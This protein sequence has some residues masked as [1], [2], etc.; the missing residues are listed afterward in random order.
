MP[1]YRGNY[2]LS[3]AARSASGTCAVSFDEER[4]VLAPETGAGLAV[5][6]GDIDSFTPGDWELSVRLYSGTMLK[7][8]RFG[9]AFPNLQRELMDAWRQRMT[10]CLL[11]GDLKELAR[12]DGFA[13]LESSELR[14]SSPAEI[15]LY[16]TN[17]AVLPVSA[18]A[19]QWRLA[20]VDFSD[21]DEET[22][23]FGLRSGQERLLLTRLARRTAEFR[24]T[25]R[26][27]TDELTRRTADLVR[28]LFPFLDPGAVRETA[29]LMREG[30]S[31]AVS[32]LSA[33][34]PRI[35]ASLETNS[36]DSRMKP[37]FERLSGLAMPGGVFTGFK[38]IRPEEEEYGS[39]GTGEADGE[40]DGEPIADQGGGTPGDSGDVELEDV[41]NWYFFVPRSRSHPD[42]PANLVAWEATNRGGRATYFFRLVPETDAGLLADPA[43]ATAAIEDGIRMINKALLVLN[44]RREPIYLPSATIESNVR[45]YRYAIACR[46]I[47]AL[48]R[49]R[50]S[51]VC[52]ILHTSVEAWEG[53][54]AAVPEVKD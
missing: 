11:L 26:H 43:K 52:R 14:F 40:A 23:T 33:I 15:R 10:K 34:D 53:K 32:R 9:K 1:D 38:L 48:R 22:C 31:A 2:Q 6:L 12:L 47:P 19:V 29:A 21:F 44:F 36:V 20:E 46:R 39:P 18:P 17:L 5:D 41:L 51:F 45:Y 49:L 35:I 28:R 50:E 3:S 16:E 24:E 4:L 30:R 54:V 8:L 27:T 7:L 42:R 37:Y 13:Q 25:Y